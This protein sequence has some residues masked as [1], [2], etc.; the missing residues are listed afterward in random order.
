MKI[1]SEKIGSNDL[2]VG[3]TVDLNS[4]LCT[5][6]SLV[7]NKAK[8]LYLLKKAIADGLIDNVSF[9]SFVI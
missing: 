8:S 4:E 9:R 3:L 5:R 2:N 1:K 7:G 6:S